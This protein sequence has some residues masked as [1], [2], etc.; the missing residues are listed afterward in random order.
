MLTCLYR[1]N[2]T[3]RFAD[4]VVLLYD[5]EMVAVVERTTILVVTVKV[6]VVAPAGTGHTVGR[7]RSRPRY[8]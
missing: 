6:A 3:V 7:V 1:Y 4:L 2:V 5:A 8:C